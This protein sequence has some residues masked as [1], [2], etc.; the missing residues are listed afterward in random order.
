MSIAQKVV[1]PTVIGFFG[2][3]MCHLGLFVCSLAG[4]NFMAYVIVYPL[5]YPLLAILLTLFAPRSW[6]TNAIFLCLIPFLYWYV[7]LWSDGR[8]NAASF[9][10]YQSSGMSLIILLALGLSA[11]AAFAAS[12][13][14]RP[15]PSPS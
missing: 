15:T 12:K 7:L 13:L 9:S 1:L 8:L 6:L 10:W 4:I 11:L 5:I 3:F 14:R 2:M